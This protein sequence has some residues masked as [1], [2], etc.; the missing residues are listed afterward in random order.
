MSLF[1]KMN[2]MAKNVTE[3]ATDA[4][5]ITR[6]NT[7][8]GEE[9]KKIIEYQRE[10]GEIIWS[11]FEIGEV[12]PPEIRELCETIKKSKLSIDAIV[13]EIQELKEEPGPGFENAAHTESP[14]VKCPACGADNED[15]TKFCGECG[16]KL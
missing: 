6:L 12:V 7:K 9:N 16:A 3:K 10:I 4:I 13:Q 1:D 8:I 14:K 2:L 11:K 15:G 5:E